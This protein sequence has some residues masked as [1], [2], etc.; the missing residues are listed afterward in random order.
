MDYTFWIIHIRQSY[1]ILKL[2]EVTKS[3]CVQSPCVLH[4]V[5]VFYLQTENTESGEEWRGFI[6][7]VT[8]VGRSLSLSF[9]FFFFKHL[10]YNKRDSVMRCHQAWSG[11][12]EINPSLPHR[13]QEHDC[14]SC[15][16]CSLG[17]ALV[18]AGGRSQRRGS[19]NSRVGCTN[20]LLELP[21]L[22]KPLVQKYLLN[23]YR[24]HTKVS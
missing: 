13:W 20:L 24:I 14:V 23:I 10:F 1:D 22:I 11:S 21:I 5:S 7:T 15:S 12:C 16:H 18:G 6:L 3:V 17:P 4:F 9:F 19:R 8:E 2:F